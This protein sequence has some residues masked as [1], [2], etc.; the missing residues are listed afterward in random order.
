[1]G[2]VFGKIVRVNLT[3]GEI[4]EESAEQHEER[5]VGGRGVGAWMLFNEL[6]TGTTSLDPASMLIFCTGPLTGTSFPGASR[7]SIE[8][9]NCRLLMPIIA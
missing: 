3:S 2:K 7:L 6:G 8:S 5:F 4:L 9:K 1:M